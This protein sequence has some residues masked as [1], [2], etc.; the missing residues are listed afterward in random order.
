[1][2]QNSLLTQL[3][4]IVIRVH[5]GLG[6]G[7]VVRETAWALSSPKYDPKKSVV[8]NTIHHSLMTEKDLGMNISNLVVGKG[9][10]FLGIKSKGGLLYKLL[11]G[12]DGKGNLLHWGNATKS[13]HK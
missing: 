1:M 2:Q 9:N 7:T 11:M 6:V 8:F 10:Y 12:S 3:S 4:G 13:A 5:I